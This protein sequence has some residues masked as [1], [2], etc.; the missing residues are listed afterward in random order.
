MKKTQK[1]QKTKPRIAIVAI[2][3]PWQNIECIGVAGSFDEANQKARAHAESY[4]SLTGEEEKFNFQPIDCFGSTEAVDEDGN[5]GYQF[6]YLDA[7]FN[8]CYVKVENRVTGEVEFK[9]P[10]H[11]Y[12]EAND[13]AFPKNSRFGFCST[14][15]TFGM[16]FYPVESRRKTYVYIP[17]HE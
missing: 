3:L 12:M 7:P 14:A 5:D 17:I 6:L 8:G 15:G 4:F 11:D 2:E 16:G 9:G 1:K 13:K 10:Y